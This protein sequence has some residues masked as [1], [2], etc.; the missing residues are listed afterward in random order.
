MLIYVLGQNSHMK[1]KIVYLFQIFSDI[2]HGLLE[3]NIY[4]CGHGQVT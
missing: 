2:Y 4:C 3:E 1:L